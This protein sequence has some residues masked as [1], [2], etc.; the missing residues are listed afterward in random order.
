MVLCK[1]MTP[2]CACSVHSSYD[3]CSYNVPTLLATAT[4][5][6]SETGV[7]VAISSYC[8]NYVDCKKLFTYDEYGPTVLTD[9][10]FRYGADGFIVCSLGTALL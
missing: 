8:C 2:L 10:L 3:Q 4:T 6:L 5:S 9:H 7:V 1:F